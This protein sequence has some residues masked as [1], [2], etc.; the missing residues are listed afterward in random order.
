MAIIKT[1]SKF[2]TAIADK[3]RSLIGKDTKYTPE[4][5]PVGVGE[6]YEAGAKAEYDAFWDALQ[7]YGNQTNYDYRFA[8]NGWNNVTFNPKYNMTISSGLR[9]FQSTGITDAK[10]VL[11]KSGV[12][13]DTSKC[14]DMRYFCAES[15]TITRLPVISFESTSYTSNAFDRCV[16]LSWID[17]IVFRLDGKN[18]F[19][20][21]FRECSSLVHVS[22]DGVIGQNGFD[23]HW[24]T[25]LNKDSITSII[26]ALSTTTSGLTVTLSKTAKEAAFTDD[27]WAALIA[28]KTNWTISLV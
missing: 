10:G 19:V 20:D 14:A 23:V 9:M 15:K 26:N 21:T 22:V 6:V 24:S 25:L 11:E 5:M 1:D 13:L 3:I 16:K 2:Y 28:T 7:S 4:D 18:T 17:K 8:S 27:E 12:V